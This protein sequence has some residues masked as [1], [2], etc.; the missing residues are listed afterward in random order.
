MGLSFKS[1]KKSIG[2]EIGTDTVK[3]VVY[4]SDGVEKLACERLPE[5]MVREGRVTAPSAMSEFLKK[6]L[7]ENDIRP[8]VCSFVL[9]SQIVI[10]H[11]VTMPV[12]G[13]QELMINL[14][15]EFRDFIGKDSEKYDYD[16]SV[17]SV[18]DNTMELYAAAVLKDVVEAYYDI[19]KKAGLTMKIAIPHEMAWINLIN[20]A[21]NE[22]KCLCIVD[23]GHHTTQV[24][25]FCNGNFVMGKSI[26]IGGALI[27]DAI[28][29][30]Q[31]IDPFVAR[32]RKDANMNNVLALD[33]CVEAYNS[34]AVEIMKVVAYYNYSCEKDSE[35][36]RDIYFCGGSCAIESL[37]LAI[38]KSTNLTMHN[39][40]RLLDLHDD[41]SPLPLYCA[42]AVGAAAQL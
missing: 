4:G 11:H 5:N 14:P 34:I 2:V 3:I 29:S 8:G 25:I 17:L 38:L 41:D 22:P 9:P 7:K 24:D 40:R 10:A 30:A 32:T 23:V 19:F 1:G 28:A 26:E 15:F 31:K 35:K 36:L 37:R 39:V 12:M 21:K 6:M 20:Q 42:I 16:Y 13:E 33:A 27:D 18:N